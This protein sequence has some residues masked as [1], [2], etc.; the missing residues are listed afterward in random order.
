MSRYRVVVTATARAHVQAVV[1]WCAENDR[2]VPET[3]LDELDAAVA[4]IGELPLSGHLY[5]PS[6]V[7]GV[8]R[9]LLR[10]SGYHV[11]YTVDEDAGDVIVRAVWYAAR[12]S[13]PTLGE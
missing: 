11:Y 13:G 7:E 1:R 10:R 6:P 8:Y 4:R 12:G 2:G 5:Q 9:V 3:F